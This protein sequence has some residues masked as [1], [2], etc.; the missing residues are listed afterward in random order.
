MR[1]LVG[2]PFVYLGIRYKFMDANLMLAYSVYSVIS[3]EGCASILW[4]DGAKAPEAAE[5]LKLTATALEELE[6]IDVIIPEPPGGA[7]RHRDEVM[8]SVRDELLKQVRRLRKG[9]AKRLVKR[10]MDKYAKIGR[11]K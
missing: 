2:L 7:H 6:L 10:R 8:G 9:S 5:A 1:I 3:P 4:R 11:F